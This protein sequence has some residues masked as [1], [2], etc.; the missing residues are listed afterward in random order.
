[1]SRRLLDPDEI[2]LSF[3]DLLPDYDGSR[4]SGSVR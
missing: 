3:V 2:A 1:M 4:P